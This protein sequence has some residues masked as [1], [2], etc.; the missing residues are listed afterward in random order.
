MEAT[1]DDISERL[2]RVYNVKGYMDKYGLDVWLTILLVLIFFLVITYFSIKNKLEPIRADWINQKCNPAVLPFAGLI[3]A[4]KGMSAI[5]FTAQNFSGCIQQTLIYVADSFMAPIYYTMSILNGLYR[6]LIIAMGAVRAFFDKIRTTVADI[7]KELMGRLVNLTIP[8]MSMQIKLRT[9]FSQVIGTLTGTFYFMLGSFMTMKSLFLNIF[10][11][12]V[13]I[14][15]LLAI[16]IIAL[17]ILTY[18][19]IIGLFSLPALFV[20]LAA[21]IMIAI[22]V[23]I[24]SLFLLDALKMSTGGIPRAPTGCFAPDTPIDLINNGKKHIKDIVNGDILRD[25]AVVTGVIRYDAKVQDMYLLHG[26]V[27]VT[28]EHRVYLDNVG[29][30]KVKDHAAS[31]L[32]TDY[33]QPYVYCLLTESKVFTVTVHV[34]EEPI[35]FSDWDDMDDANYQKLKRNCL[36]LPT[37]FDGLAHVHQHLDG[38]L[39]STTKIVVLNN[40]NEKVLVNI[41]DVQV[42]DV[43]FDLKGRVTRVLGVVHI[44][45]TDLPIVKY[46]STEFNGLIGS[47]NLLF[48][49]DLGVITNALELPEEAFEMYMDENVDQLHHLLTSSGYF[50]V[51]LNDDDRTSLV[52]GDYN[53]GLDK[54]LVDDDDA[55]DDA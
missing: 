3:N 24:I 53:T 39:I 28:G 32:V 21:F 47:R 36:Q 22:I 30:I 20:T 1:A 8:L 18:V 9:V 49:T 6:D 37:D 42:G 41:A 35:I 34:D 45:A 40:E 54:Y 43:L 51:A 2:N 13:G 27:Q 46:S 31:T 44:L 5:E 16:T 33:S 7:Q 12:L 29:W 48:E 19:P 26:H 4:P 52:V 11:L 55:D 50:T 15:I 38:G 14:L 17:F 23:I 25:G 10:N